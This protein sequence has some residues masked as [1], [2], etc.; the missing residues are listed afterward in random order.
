VTLGDDARRIRARVV[1]NA[2][3]PWVSDVAQLRQS[4]RAA[5]AAIRLVK[6]SHIVVPRIADARDAYTLQN[7]DGRVVFALPFES[8]F[9]LI[10][11]TEQPQTHNPR[12]A[13]VTA[14]EETY[15]LDAA[16][17]YFRVPLKRDAIVWRFA[18]V[19][20]LDDDGSTDAS[21]ITRDYRLVVEADGS[22]PILHVI[23]GKI[24]TYRKLAEAAL[25]LLEPYLPAMRR[26]ST[27]TALLPGGDFEGRTWGAWFEDFARAYAGFERSSLLRLARRYGTRTSRVIEGAS[28]EREL[29]KDFGAGLRAREVAYLKSEEWAE[30]ADDVLWRRTKAGLALAPEARGRAA[31]ALQDY[32]DK[33]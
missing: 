9:T 21:A 27:R 1:V 6:G 2:A 17:R 26:G 31:E 5:P 29:G 32:L 28:S 20:P 33:L 15:L 11:T 13:S 23:G 24:T 22:P 19:R 14:D 25:D 18:G 16:N 7:S 4:H 3:G 30:T 8:D 12:M 10:G